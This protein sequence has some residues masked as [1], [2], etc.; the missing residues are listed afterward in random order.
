MSQNCYYDVVPN[1]KRPVYYD[2]PVLQSEVCAD[3]LTMRRKQLEDFTV[4]AA[5]LE[6]NCFEPI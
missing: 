5:L 1:A 6:E 2:L 4:D 3:L